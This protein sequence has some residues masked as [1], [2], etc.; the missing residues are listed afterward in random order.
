MV[1]F[2]NENMK[3]VLLITLE[4]EKMFV[5]IIFREHLNGDEYLYWYSVQ[6]ETIVMIHEKVRKRM[7]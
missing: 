1:K 5:E 2:L 4:G 6:G 7:R 3:D